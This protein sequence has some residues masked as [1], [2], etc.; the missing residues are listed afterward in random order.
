MN[1]YNIYIYTLKTY[2]DINKYNI[3]IYKLLIIAKFLNNVKLVVLTL[4]P[5]HLQKHQFICFYRNCLSNGLSISGNSL[6]V[7]A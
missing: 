2:L 7:N 6:V 3:Y 4:F 1:K 5:N